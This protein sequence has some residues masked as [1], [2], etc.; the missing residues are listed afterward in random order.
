MEDENG[1]D[2][3]IIAVPDH[4]VDPFYS[5]VRSGQHLPDY[6]KNQIEHFF[7]HYKET[8]P[9]KFVKIK[10]WGNMAL[11]KQL[12]MKGIRSSKRFER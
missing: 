5:D 2:P 10:G 4:S 7:K 12:I 8:E 3:K 1:D 6:T 11:A 9:N